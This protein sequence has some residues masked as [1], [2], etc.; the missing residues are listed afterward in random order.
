MQDFYCRVTLNPESSQPLF[1]N[2]VFAC[3]MTKK[4]EMGICVSLLV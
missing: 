4:G 2:A 3:E 1:S